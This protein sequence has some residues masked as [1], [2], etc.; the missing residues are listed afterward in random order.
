MSSL[1]SF[2]H[3]ID[4]RNNA[5]ADEEDED[6]EEE[7]GEE[8]EEDGEEEDEDEKYEA[9]EEEDEREEG[10]ETESSGARAGEARR[11]P[12]LR[13]VDEGGGP[14]A[15][16]SR[17]HKR[18]VSSSA[19]DPSGASRRRR[20][21]SK[22][23][24]SNAVRRSLPRVTPA[25]LQEV[26]LI[27]AA[28]VRRLGGLSAALAKD[29][30]GWDHVEACPLLVATAKEDGRRFVQLPSLLRAVKLHGKAAGSVK[31]HW[32]EN[33]DTWLKFVNYNAHIKGKA[34]LCSNQA[35]CS[36]VASVVVPC[37]I[38]QRASW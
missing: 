16:A 9:E 19:R 35:L 29:A 21:S 24:G 15:A 22:G 8:E 2:A 5:A 26:D 18:A 23:G 25:H 38:F 27:D 12:R 17:R 10:E 36:C 13:E 4:S 31:R 32:R 1:D 6:E 3:R 33:V 37:V 30:L 34:A 14:A 28:S 20:S 7:E 11:S